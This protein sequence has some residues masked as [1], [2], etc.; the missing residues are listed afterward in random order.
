VTESEI[1]E[2]KKMRETYQLMLRA[3]L[4]D[5]P[6]PVWRD[7]LIR[8]DATFFD[9]HIKLQA[10]F[11]WYDDH[12]FIF[13]VGRKK[14]IEDDAGGWENGVKT[15]VSPGLWEENHQPGE[16]ESIVSLHNEKWKRDQSFTYT[17][18]IGNSIE[19]KLWVLSVTPFDRTSLPPPC[20]CRVVKLKG[21]SPEQYAYRGDDQRYSEKVRALAPLA[22]PVSIPISA[23]AEDAI[24]AEWSDYYNRRCV[25]SEGLPT[26]EENLRF[27]RTHDTTEKMLAFYKTD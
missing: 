9:L 13:D 4:D 24:L 16:V 12:A 22:K 2:E 11:V 27:Y 14:P 8:S 26:R 1:I 17:Y 6:F 15:Y 3:K 25:N 23:K 19:I 5:W 18:D 20:R 10:A 21:F 7:I